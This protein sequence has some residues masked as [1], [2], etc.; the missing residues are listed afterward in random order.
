M[1]VKP[2]P[3]GY[4]SV[5]PYLVVDDGAKALEFYKKAF[6]AKELM[7]L[8]GPDG[9]IAHAEIQIGDSIVMM[10]D[11]APARGARSAKSIGGS[12]IGL[13][14][15]V[16]DVDAQFK[17]AVAAGATVVMPV[18]DQFY[19]DRNGTVSD[20]FGLKWTL[21]THKEDVSPEEMKKRMQAMMKPK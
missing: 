1:A 6:G 18:A 2:I 20:P 9:K 5:T 8:P 15:Y 16:P 17:Q 19:G 14:V 12:P 10:A 11:E 21:G 4:R 3:D 13:M 7:R